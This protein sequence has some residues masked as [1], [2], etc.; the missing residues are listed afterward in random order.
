[1]IFHRYMFNKNP[2]VSTCRPINKRPTRANDLKDLGD[3]MEPYFRD[4][5]LSELESYRRYNNEEHKD[6]IKEPKYKEMEEAI[7]ACLKKIRGP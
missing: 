2:N 6:D 7:Q 1:M 4:F 5:C 3:V